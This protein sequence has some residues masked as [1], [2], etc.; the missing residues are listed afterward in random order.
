MWRDDFSVWQH[1]GVD[2][3]AVGTA[4]IAGLQAYTEPE[5]PLIC[6]LAISVMD[7]DDPLLTGL[8]IPVNFLIVFLLDELVSVAV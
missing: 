2:L 3:F 6:Q 1:D 4:R 8:S 5:D 7:L